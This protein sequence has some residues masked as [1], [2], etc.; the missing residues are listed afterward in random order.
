M[1]ATLLEEVEPITR[2]EQVWTARAMCKFGGSFT[3][4]LGRALCLA[5]EQNAQTIKDTWPQEWS[6]YSTLGKQMEKEEK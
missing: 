6:Y 1:T 3:H 4:S 5:D 2:D